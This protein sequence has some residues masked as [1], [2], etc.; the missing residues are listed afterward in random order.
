MKYN[1]IKESSVIVTHNGGFHAD[2]VFCVAIFELL[3][4]SAVKVIR[5]RNAEI[6]AEAKETPNHWVF[7]VG[8]EY[9]TEKLC[10]DHHQD[11]ETDQAS[12]GRFMEYLL[13]D[14]LDHVK[15]SFDEDMKYAKQILTMV[16]DSFTREVDLHDTGNSDYSDQN[17]ITISKHVSLYNGE[18]L[19]NTHIQDKQ[20]KSAVKMVKKLLTLFIDRELNKL[21]QYDTIKELF[22]TQREILVMESYPLPWKEYACSHPEILVKN[23]FHFALYPAKGTEWRLQAMPDPV[24]SERYSIRTKIPKNWEEILG[25]G[26]VSPEGHLAQFFRKYQA[27]ELASELIYINDSLVE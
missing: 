2:E 26:F 5:T 10:F 13:N 27:I 19:T 1:P 18:D 23:N 8:R 9:D 7:D 4:N 3:V 12:I 20:F 21:K 17:I 11:T 22:E 25:V 14:G 16:V 24:T 15:M 6:I